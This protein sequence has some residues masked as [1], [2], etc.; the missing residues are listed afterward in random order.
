[1]IMTVIWVVAAWTAA[2]F[3]VAVPVGAALRREREWLASR[4]PEDAA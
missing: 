2:A 1:M 4:D 3:L